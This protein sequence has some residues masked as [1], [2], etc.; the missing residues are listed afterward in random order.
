MKVLTPID[1]TDAMLVAANITEDDY[2]EW[3]AATNYVIGDYVISTATH[4]VY[5]A[6]VASG[7]AT[8]AVDPDLE[9]ANFTDPLVDT[10]AET[11]HW[12][13]IGATNLWKLFDKKPS[14]QAINADTIDVSLTPGDIVGGIGLFNVNASSV[15]VTVTSAAEGLVYDQT[16]EL[17][18]NENVTDWYDFFFAA[19][20][21]L[22][23][24]TFLE[25]P[26]YADATYR[27]VVTREAGTAYVGQIVLG[28]VKDLGTTLIGGT[29][30]DGFDFSTISTDV[31]GNI[32]TTRR[33]ATRVNR[34]RVLAQMTRMQA[35]ERILNDLRGG[36]PAVWIG[37][38]D[39][40]VN[41]LA[42]GYARDW[43]VDYLDPEANA[44]NLTLEIQ[45]IV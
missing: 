17:V 36:V 21:E 14:V 8:T 32:Q 16:R 43:R 44:A 34:F 37:A 19:I 13:I 29:G 7:P 27:I 30:F 40:R 4:T 39:D 5:R 6:L 20:E 31:F 3:S 24:I 11:R 22:D 26:P 35:I 2:A 9:A 18:D 25:L 1:P 33:A 45:G 15:R 42:Y 12:Q 23:E 41:A 38:T 10:S 28:S